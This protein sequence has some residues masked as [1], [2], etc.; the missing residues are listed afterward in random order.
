[1]DSSKSFNLRLL[2]PMILVLAF[3]FSLGS[4]GQL[5]YTPKTYN[6]DSLLKVLPKNKGKAKVET[7]LSLSGYHALHTPDS[8]IFY[9]AKAL[10]FSELYKDPGKVLKSTVSLGLAYHHKGDYPSAVKFGLEGRNLAFE[11]NDTASVVHAVTFVVLSYLYSGNNDLAIREALELK[12]YLRNWKDPFRSFDLQ[13][14][15]GWLYLMAERYR[16]AILYFQSCDAIVK[17]NNVIPGPFRDLNISHLAT[18]YMRLALY[19]SAI[20]HYT[21]VIRADPDPDAPVFSFA[22]LQIG[23]CYLN[24]NELDSAGKYLDKSLKIAGMEG[25]FT[26]LGSAQ[27][28]RAKIRENRKQWQEALKLYCEAINAG[29]WIL[30]H[31]SESILTDPHDGGWYVPEQYVPDHIETTGLNLIMKAH[32]NSYLICR[33]LNQPG[34]A[35]HHLEKYNEA[36]NRQDSLLKKREV[37]ELATRYETQRKEEEIL[38]L[39][40][41][42]EMAHSRLTNTRNTMFVLAALLLLL[43]VSGILLLGQYRLKN[44][45]ET[46]LLKQKLFRAQMNPHFIFNALSGIQ[47]FIM[48][49]DHIQA[50][51]YLSRFAKLVRNILLGSMEESIE[52]SKEVEAID[53]YL[54]LQKIRYSGQFEYQILTDESLNEQEIRIP[55]MLVQP[56]IEN[57][58]EHGIKHKDTPGKVLVSFRRVSEML[59]IEIFDNGVGRKKANEIEKIRE[60]DGSSI[61]TSL[62]MDRIKSLNREHRKLRRGQRFSLQIQDLTNESGEAAGTRVILKVPLMIG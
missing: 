27:I 12:Q 18:C 9:A 37:L 35:I 17:A 48:Q 25:D 29:E 28:R 2:L 56:F 49:Q 59:E 19:D 24:K 5:F 20:F 53:H 21:R 36:K 57:A 15:M 60:R 30:E 10:K 44:L 40:R 50:A 1:M 8:G 11:Y 4:F 22:Y 54:Q 47:G 6:Y 23:N 46:S 45:H 43:V 62:I 32:Y 52:L 55:P 7:L 3:N 39:S 58:I 41:E 14:R 31:H 38:R 16:E 42:K 61:A 33:D 51:T 13:I 26:L 34:K